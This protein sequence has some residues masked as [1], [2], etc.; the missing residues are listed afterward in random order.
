MQVPPCQ[1]NISI[2]TIEK[3]TETSAARRV[4]SPAISAAPAINS[5]PL[6]RITAG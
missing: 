4:K 6:N 2:S 3:P 1:P 5:A